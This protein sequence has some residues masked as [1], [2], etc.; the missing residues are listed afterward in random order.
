M[1]LSKIINVNECCITVSSIVFLNFLLFMRFPSLD[2]RCVPLQSDNC[3]S[4]SVRFF[5]ILF[6]SE[7]PNGITLQAKLF[8]LHTPV[9]SSFLLPPFLMIFRHHSLRLKILHLFWLPFVLSAVSV[10]TDLYQI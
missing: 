7:V 4:A 3:P 1:I 9:L 8:S 6:L 2:H 10:T 5:H